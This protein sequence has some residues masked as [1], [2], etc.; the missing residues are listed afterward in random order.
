MG[1]KRKEDQ[2]LNFE[3]KQQGFIVVYQYIKLRVY[4]L[5]AAQ[6]LYLYKDFEENKATQ[7]N[8]IQSLM[9][10]LELK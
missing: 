6:D 2:C 8:G 1:R 7:I 10:C 3:E 5:E 4:E 9:E